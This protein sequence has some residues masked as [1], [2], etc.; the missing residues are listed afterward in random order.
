[1]ILEIIMHSLLSGCL[2]LS[3]LYLKCRLPL[4]SILWLGVLVLPASTGIMI[5]IQN[6]LFEFSFF[7]GLL[8]NSFFM[9]ILIF[10]IIYI[11]F[12]RDPERIPPKE[13]N[14]IVSPA[15]GQIRYIREIKN[16]KIPVT[17]K[18]GK[19][20]RLTDIYQI[21]FLPKEA[22][23]IGIEMNLLDV[24][25][26]RA[27]V[28]G[29]LL[30]Q[31]H[32]KGLYRSLRELDTLFENERV[33]TIIKNSH[34]DIGVIQIASRF[35]RRIISYHSVGKKVELGERIGMIKLGSQVDLIIPAMNNVILLC[36][37][38]E[39]VRAGTSIIA[40]IGSSS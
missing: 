38:G 24:N 27:P 40:E 12:H 3:I 5:C 13:E 2:F 22:I 34:M 18:K 35:V 21:R 11:R 31:N 28:S 37:Q 6:L 20:I 4:R 23:Q 33:S 19:Y 26:N 15:D 16:G 17:N 10:I 7:E 29:Q 14:I 25:V 1:M 8:Q 32:V 36:R 9:G 39:R 30:Y